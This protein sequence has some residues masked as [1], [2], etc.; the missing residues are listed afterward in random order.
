MSLAASLPVVV[1]DGVDERGLAEAARTSPDAFA[2]LY[3][4]YVGRIHAFAFKEGYLSEPKVFQLRDAKE[5]GIPA[6]LAL[7]GDARRLFVAN[8][9]G[10]RIS[11]VDIGETAQVRDIVLSAADG[12]SKPGVTIT[13]E[14]HDT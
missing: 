10:Q 7:S 13:V 2:V 3:R 11:Q 9:W 14:R 12:A 5:R 1:P 6:G 8:V 4:R